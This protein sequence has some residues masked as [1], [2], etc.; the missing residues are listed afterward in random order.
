MVVLS[1]GSPCGGHHKGS[2]GQYTEDVIKN[3]EQTHV[4]IVGVGIKFDAVK[5]YYRKWAYIEDAHKIESTLLSLISNH[6][7]RSV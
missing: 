2:I 7:I 5:H 6:I 1:D 4:D 3:I